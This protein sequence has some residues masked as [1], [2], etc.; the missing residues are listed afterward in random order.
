MSTTIDGGGVA[1]RGID[2]PTARARY[3]YD[4]IDLETLRYAV[5]EVSR[6]MMDALMRSGFSPI[7]RDIRDCTACVHM[8]TDAGWEMIASTEG[9][10][11][12]AFTSQHIVNFAMSEWDEEALRPGDTIFV[13][14]PWRGAIHC[15]D[16]NVIRPVL[17]DG[18]PEFILHTTSHVADLGGAT[19]GGFAQ[20]V[21]TCFE[22]QLKF[23]PMLLYAEDVPVRST[24]NYL[25]E[26][27]R[28]PAMMLGDLRALAGSLAVGEK[29]LKELIER[30][31]VDQVRAGSAYGMDIT[32]AAM[33]A[34]IRRLPD[35][36]YRAEDIID[37]DVIVQE[38]IPVVMTVKVRGDELE[39]DYSESAR[40]PRGSVGS[41]WVEAVRPI[42]G[43][44]MLLDPSSPVNSGTLRPIQAIMPPGS[45]VLVLPPASCSD[46][47][48]IG[49]RAVDLITTALGKADPEHAIAADCG[50]AGMLAVSGID[51]RPG[52]EG[53]PW[54]SFALPGGGWGAT[55][56]GDG[57]SCCI[58][59][60]G[61]GPR[62]SVW[63]HIE[64]EAP[65]RIWQHE[66]MP[67]SAGAGKH[68]GG[69][70]GIYAVEA[71]SPTII[72]IVGDRSRVGAPG[73]AGGGTG[74]PFYAWLSEDFKGDTDPTDLRGWTPMFGM[75]DENGIPDPDGGA[76]SAGTLYPSAKVPLMTLQPGQAVRLVIGGGGGWGDPLERDPEAALADVED[77]Y[78]S[79]AFA[80]RYHGVVVL[81]EERLDLD[82]T[83]SLRAELRAK[84][85]VGEWSVPTACPPSW[86]V[87]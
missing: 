24:F 39:I 49:G 62:T 83:E 30:Y 64:E 68:R 85:E 81:D 22:E 3:G 15:S 33:R 38:P 27:N 29:R 65:L 18:R 40:Q 61:T 84:R 52:R 26:N 19:P 11:Q 60:L 7:V 13:N 9:C 66:L 53:T 4:L 77:G 74:M 17:V 79:A 10:V 36:D 67:D 54:A 51:G 20:G 59:A 37:D 45:T 43:A 28:V 1:E 42:V 50:H 21:E 2:A 76:F 80:E 57:L 14:D 8:R 73:V 82:A 32:E 86:R 41:A 71:I 75:L 87:D 25:L 31:D 78:T 69:L 55:W 5:I 56:K 72:S 44:K 63:E 58:I 35:G 47:V 12:H 70:G 48:E 6:D 23:P 16:V 34:G 46:H